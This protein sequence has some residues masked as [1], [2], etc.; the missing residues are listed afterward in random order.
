MKIDDKKII[1]QIK[2]VLDDIDKG[3]HR[4]HQLTCLINIIIKYRKG[5]I[6]L[7]DFEVK[8]GECITCQSLLWE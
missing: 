1:E 7:L 4:N 5:K 6:T 8:Q 3:E 2:Y